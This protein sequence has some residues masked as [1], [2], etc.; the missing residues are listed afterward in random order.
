MV[1]GLSAAGVIDPAWL[2][3]MA[4][5]PVVFALANP[6]PDVDVDAAR[7]V[8][9]VIATGR[10]DYPNQ[11]NNVLAFPGV[12]RGL[13]DARARNVTTAMLLRAADALAARGHRRAAQRLLRGAQRL[14]PAG[15]QGG[16]RGR[17]RR[18]RGRPHPRLG[19]CRPTGLRQQPDMGRIPA[20]LH[21]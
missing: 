15:A 5:E 13:L 10:S 8:A 9:A 2:E 19:P 1:I 4:P 18:R 20:N 3:L 21:P 12:F 7:K 17:R 16:R 11:I 14:R 6:D